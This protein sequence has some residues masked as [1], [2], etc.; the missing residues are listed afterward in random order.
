MSYLFREMYMID[1]SQLNGIWTNSRAQRGP[2]NEVSLCHLVDLPQHQDPKVESDFLSSH[3]PFCVGGLY[4]AYPNGSGWVLLLQ[5]APANFSHNFIDGNDPYLVMNNALSRTLSFNDQAA[6]KVESYW[7][8]EDLVQ[9][10]EEFG[11][12]REEL[13]K[14]T[15]Y[16][17]LSGLL[18]ECCNVSLNYLVRHGLRECAFPDSEHSCVL[19]P[20]LDV[21]AQ[22]QG[23]NIIELLP[24]E[25]M[26]VSQS[27][28]DSTSE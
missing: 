22:W 11:A 13:G 15:V 19:N 6:L 1:N 26:R 14:W 25:N 10:Y 21:F 5:K 3:L 2:D 18:A 12:D 28:L 24:D 17:M 4:G 20:F 27:I 9:V 8:K 16:Q 23:Q 7:E